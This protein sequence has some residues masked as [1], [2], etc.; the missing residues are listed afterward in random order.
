MTQISVKKFFELVQQSKLV[1]EAELV[2]A[3]KDYKQAHQGKVPETAT[4]LAAELIRLELLTQWH[5]DKLL[6]GKYKGFFLGKYKLLRHLGAGG[7]S[8]VY[9]AEHVLMRQLRAIKVLPRSR[10]N[11]SSYLDRFHLEA[12]ATAALDHPNIVRAY[13]IDNDGDTHYLV[14]EYV[15]GKDLQTI[16]KEARPLDFEQAARYIAQAAEGLD[17]VHQQGLIHRDVKPANLLVDEE[18][19]IKVLDLGLALFSDDAKMA[20]VTLTHN[21]SILGT[22]DYLAPEQAVNSHNVDS[23][24]DIYG[25]GCTL[26]FVL[27]GRALFP[28]GSLAER[29]AKHQ[30]ATPDSILAI[31]ENC[32]ESLVAICNKMI[33]KNPDDR[34]QT[35]GEINQVLS[36]YQSKR[37][38][39]KVNQELDKSIKELG[40]SIKE[41]SQE[42]DKSI[43]ERSQELDKSIK[44]F[45]EA[46][47]STPAIVVGSVLSDGI[48]DLD[49]LPAIDLAALEGLEVGEDASTVNVE[50]GKRDQQLDDEGQSEENRG[51]VKDPRLSATAVGSQAGKSGSNVRDQSGRSAGSI[52]MESDSSRIDLGIEV[53]GSNPAQASRTRR[54][55]EERQ[56][57]KKYLWWVVG[58]LVLAALLFIGSRAFRSNSAG[59]PD[60]SATSPVESSQSREDTAGGQ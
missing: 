47:V 15:K 31:R 1:D 37:S 48:G 55:L 4:E 46:A 34:Y 13:D 12:Q 49:Q 9:L 8:S 30:K 32:P 3:M 35:C 16:V 18:D 58:G 19:T 28:E 43:K 2:T 41:R 52:P 45:E 50:P 60:S 56:G 39:G 23:R 6:I 20:S 54:L 38:R 22:A 17:Y 57:R 53:W 33:E 36:E 27:T 42:V 59:Q 24:V 10:V 7:M 29:I 5:C 11:D 40:K 51:T 44:E 14:M 25:L 26:Y 21:E